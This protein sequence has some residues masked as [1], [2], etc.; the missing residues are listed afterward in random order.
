MSVLDVFPMDFLMIWGGGTGVL[1]HQECLIRQILGMRVDYI[2]IK[3]FL[4]GKE[5]DG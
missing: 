3:Y 2:S 5:F 4:F 1:G